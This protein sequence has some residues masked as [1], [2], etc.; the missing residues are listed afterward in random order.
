MRLI[1]K[2][3]VVTVCGGFT[4]HTNKEL[5]VDASVVTTYKSGDMKIGRGKGAMT[6]MAKEI[7]QV[8]HVDKE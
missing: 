8:I 2:L 7:V 6:Y 4:M 1:I 3:S 5:L